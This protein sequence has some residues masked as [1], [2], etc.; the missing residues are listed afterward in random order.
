MKIKVIF[1]NTIFLLTLEFPIPGLTSPATPGVN[2]DR[3]VVIY[4]PPKEE[5]L[6]T[7]YIVEVDGKPVP[8]YLAQTQHHDKKPYSFAYFDFSGTVTVKIKTNR[9]LDALVIRPEKY[10]IKPFIGKGEATFTT[11]KQFKISFE[12]TGANTPLLL[13]SNPI[14]ENPPRQGDPNVVYF[15]PG[16]HKP[17]KIELTSGQTLYIAGGAVVKGA[18]ISKG[19][20]IRIMGRGILDGNDW[21]HSAGP[22]ARLVTTN[23]GRNIV[24][25][26]LICRGSWNW[27]IQ[28]TRCNQVTIENV[29]LCG[30][31][32]GNDD[33]VDPCNTSNLTV[34]NCFFRTDDD[35]IA[36]KGMARTEQ[37]WMPMENIVVED[38][39]FWVD[40]ANVFRMG[41]ESRSLGLRNFTA[42]NIDVIH[43]LNPANPRVQI[44][45]LL[46]A[47]NMPMENL[48]FE[49]IR[50]NGETPQ[51]LVKIVP[52]V[53]NMWSRR[54]NPILVPGNGPYVHNVVF[55]NIEVYGEHKEGTTWGTLIIGGLNE[56]HNVQ[57]ITFENFTRYGKLLKSDSPN[58]EIR[59]FVDQIKF[60]G[61]DTTSMPPVKPE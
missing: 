54:G 58:M 25:Q 8:V 10:G 56:R 5:I 52:E 60:L 9:Q 33:G 34:R 27:T 43:S 4:P 28:L 55:R 2:P 35:A 51:N 53:N 1:I 21:P 11:D 61:P 47:D 42:R 31:R 19:D 22:A 48:V 24:I 41:T 36:V 18:V 26:D 13:F 45:Y 50:I 15:G 30:S 49:N 59:Q 40:Y 37:E 6:S 23:D 57:A 20:N 39:T 16:T 29:K 12:P 32:V 17:V 3:A 7:D 46:P 44:F 14:E 38:C